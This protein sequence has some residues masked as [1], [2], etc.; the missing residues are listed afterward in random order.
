VRAG[1]QEGDRIAINDVSTGQAPAATAPAGG[2][3]AYQRARQ[4]QGNPLAPR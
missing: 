1:L 2:I 3:G 4:Q